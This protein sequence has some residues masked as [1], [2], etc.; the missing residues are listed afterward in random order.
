MTDW[1]DGL[2]DGLAPLAA[3]VAGEALRAGR[4][5][6]AD[7]DVVVAAWDFRVRGGSFGARDASVFV[8]ACDEAARLRVPLLSLIRSGGTRLQEGMAALVGIPRTAIALDR[9]AAAGVA[10]LAVA[11]QPT[12]GGV[13]V[14]VG[15]TADLRVAVRGAT[16]GFSGPRVVQAMTGSA[17][18]PE[19]NTADDAARAGLVDDVVDPGRVESWLRRALGALAADDPLGITAP[20]PV[21]APARTGWQ[22]VRHSRTVDRPAGAVLVEDMLS[23]RVALHG[24]DRTAAASLG[25]IAGRRVVATALAADRAG[26]VGVGGYALLAR[27]AALAD[28]LDL[29]LVTLVDTAGADPLPA[30]ER[31]GIAAAIAH[32]M[33]AVLACRAPTVSVVHG[34]GGS[35]GALAA[36]V[37]DVVGVTPHGWFAALSPEGAA[38]ALR[39]TP[40]DAADLMRLTPADLLG[41]GFADAAAPADPSAL[42]AWLAGR[43]DRLRAEPA[44]DRLARR[45]ERWSGGL[46]ASTGNLGLRRDTDDQREHNR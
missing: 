37:T 16:V 36:A 11:D 15:A 12:T 10:H 2:V 7:C 45:R 42:T 26:R 28:R 27:A 23:H 41:D 17:L 14:S 46:P 43:I 29:A 24:A 34:E 44:T 9:L 30:S 31:G 8:A 38:A 1:R 20:D 25:R 5:R 3:D 13:W 35:G 22:Q 40:E 39:R 32:A 21:S 19:A 33:R 6:V 4:A 18:P